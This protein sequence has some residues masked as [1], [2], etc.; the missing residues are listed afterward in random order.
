MHVCPR[1]YAPA[2]VR[3][4]HAIRVKT[5]SYMCV[6]MHRAHLPQ[7]YTHIRLCIGETLHT[8]ARKQR[9]RLSLRETFRGVTKARVNLSPSFK[10][11]FLS[12][13]STIDD[14]FKIVHACAC[15]LR[16]WVFEAMP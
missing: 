4:A 14:A 15:R 10:V 11:S 5:Q 16:L 12:P 9:A 7:I 8:D 3:Y 13:C 2:R 1:I 6:H